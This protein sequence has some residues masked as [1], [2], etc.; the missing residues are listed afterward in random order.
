[1]SIRPTWQGEVQLRRWSE[2]STQGVQV[3]FALPD[4]GDLDP[5]KAK[6]GKR[7][8]AVLVEIGDDEQPVQPRRKDQRGPL[9]REACDLCAMPDFQAW[10]AEAGGNRVATEDCAKQYILNVCDVASRK[11]LDR[12]APAADRFVSN[13]RIPFI[14]WRRQRR[15]A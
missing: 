9:C 14:R 10:V 4:S 7:F 6:S 1:V 11:D 13:I 8:M 2:S 5:F 12:H 3:T 15:A